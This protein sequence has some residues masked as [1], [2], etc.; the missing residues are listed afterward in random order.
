ISGLDLVR[1]VRMGN[2]D[3]KVILI[4]GITDSEIRQQVTEFGADR[5][6]FKPLDLVE[7]QKSATRFLGFDVASLPEPPAVQSQV[8]VSGERLPERLAQ[9][10]LEMQAA[11]VW[12]ADSQGKIVFKV[13]EIPESW[14][15]AD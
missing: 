6:F 3:L 11:C 5:Y 2:P 9:L 12:V 14:N 4:T 10:Q 1:K 7:F 13:G 15:I 8:N